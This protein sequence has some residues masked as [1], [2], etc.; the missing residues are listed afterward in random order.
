[1]KDTASR[2]DHMSDNTRL[3]E[4]ETIQLFFGYVFFASFATLTDLTLLYTLT[5]LVNVWYFYSALISYSTGI[6]VN[7][8]MNKYLNFKNESKQILP[9][10]GVFIVV[11]LIGLA[12]NQM[13]MYLL[14][15][16]TGLW[17]MIAKLISISIVVFWSF[18]G[19]RKLTFNL[20]K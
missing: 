6:L 7:Y 19:H 2:S 12:L 9:Q 4:N 13:I 18:T 1:M 17:Y 5:E 15:E 16:Y 11:A 10:L 14:V 20:F 3:L 8:S